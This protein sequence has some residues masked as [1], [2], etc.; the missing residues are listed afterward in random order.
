MFLKIDGIGDYV[1]FR[2][3]IGITAESKKFSGYELSLCGNA[4]WKSAAEFLDGKYLKNFIWVDKKKFGKRSNWEYTYW[5]LLKIY[6]LRCQFII[7][8]NDSE[9]RLTGFILERCKTA[10]VIKMNSGSLVL[11]DN[12]ARLAENTDSLQGKIFQFY[13]NRKSFEELL[14][15]KIKIEKPY[16]ELPE[17]ADKDDYTV[18]FPG[19]GFE[20][21]RWSC[22]NFSEVIRM[23]YNSYNYKTMICGSEEDSVLAKRIIEDTGSALAEDM[24]GK[25]SVLELIHIIAKA[26][27]L[28]SNDTC[29]IHIAAAVNTRAVCISNG[30]HYGR[31]NPYPS[32]MTSL[33]S[34]IYPPNVNGEFADLIKKY[35]IYSRED[36]NRIQPEIVYEYV[37]Q[38]LTAGENKVVNL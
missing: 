4:D 10:R 23:I 3:F 21:R 26:R 15:E 13:R 30:N 36:I 14:D 33:I 35:H 18:I 11:S 34:T 16:I 22:R 7:L 5:I 12:E 25:T 38:L 9:N 19:A 32:K 2:N 8:P 24:T 1:L 29:A 27:F 6:F 31:F 17:E 20:S 28:I 37:Q